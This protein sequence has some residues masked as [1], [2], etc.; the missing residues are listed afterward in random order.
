MVRYTR[1]RDHVRAARF[2]ASC[3]DAPSCAACVRIVSSLVYACVCVA[4]NADSGCRRQNVWLL[5]A[6]AGASPSRPMPPHAS[7]GITLTCA[8]VSVVIVAGCPRYEWAATSW[9]A[10]SSSWRATP[11]PSNAT[12]IHVRPPP[13]RRPPRR[14]PPRPCPCFLQPAA[15]R[16]CVPDQCLFVVGGLC[17]CLCLCLCLS[18]W[19]RSWPSRGRPSVAHPAA[20]IRGAGSR[21]P[22]E[23]LRWH[24][25]AIGAH[26]QRLR[27][28]SVHPPRR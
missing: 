27:Q 10:K 11:R 17:L 5:H 8:V 15:A 25:A 7:G 6:R 4:M 16:F 21:H 28:E 18:V 23:H 13:P 2:S 26:L 9:W 19:C 1:W 12:K 24:P 3:D 22:R 20:A 14:P